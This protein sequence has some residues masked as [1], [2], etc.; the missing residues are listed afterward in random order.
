MVRPRRN[1]ADEQLQLPVWDDCGDIGHN[2][3]NGKNGARKRDIIP[4]GKNNAGKRD[5]IPNGK[6]SPKPRRSEGQWM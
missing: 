1:L 4:N 2:I 6:I 5:I 3:P